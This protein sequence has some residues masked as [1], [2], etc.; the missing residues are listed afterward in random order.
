MKNLF[1]LAVLAGIAFLVYKAMTEKR[2]WTGLTETEARAKLNEKLSARVSAE[3]L[4]RMTDQI[5]DKMRSRGVLRTEPA[6]DNGSSG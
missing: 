5:V 4:D 6:V 1:R 3:R 2:N